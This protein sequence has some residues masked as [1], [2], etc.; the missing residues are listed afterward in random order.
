MNS[1]LVLP[2]CSAEHQGC[3]SILTESQWFEMWMNRD[4]TDIVSCH[5]ALLQP[6]VSL[7]DSLAVVLIQCS[8]RLDLIVKVF[9]EWFRKVLH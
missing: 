2:V 7:F 1:A 5:Q 6:N 9:N 4:V 3:D 8:E